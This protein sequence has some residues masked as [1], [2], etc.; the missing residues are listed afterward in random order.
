MSTFRRP[1]KRPIVAAV[2]ASVALLSGC[3]GGGSEPGVAADVGGEEISVAEVDRATTAICTSVEADLRGSGNT[4]ALANVRQFVVSLLTAAAQAR[5]LAEEYGVEPGPEYARQVAQLETTAEAFPEGARD[6]YVKVMST[7][8]LVTGVAD[9]VGR[10]ALAREGVAEPEV[11]Q[12]SQRGQELF[13]AW[14]ETHDVV[15]DPRYGLEISGG[16]LV[17]ADTNL[18]VA[19]SDQA[20]AAMAAEPDPVYARTLPANHRCG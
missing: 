18:S 14:P 12:V 11:E 15:V 19:V 5:A 9:A 2:L 3:A 6:D 17:P 13:E 1:T 16:Q 4:V 10:E 7:E 20:K 8:A